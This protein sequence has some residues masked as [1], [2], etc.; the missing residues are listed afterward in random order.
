[1]KPTFVHIAFIVLSESILFKGLEA[2]HN[3]DDV[4]P[5]LLRNTQAAEADWIL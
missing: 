4:S 2:L 3:L 5:S 1:M